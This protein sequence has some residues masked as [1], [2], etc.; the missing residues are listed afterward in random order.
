MTQFLTVDEVLDLHTDLVTRFG[1]IAG[2]RDLGLLESAL[3]QPSLALAYTQLTVFELAAIYCFGIIKNH[4]F[5]DG[6]KRTGLLAAITFLYHNGIEIE[7]SFE[8]LYKLAVGIADS[9]YQLSFI[10][11]F[12]QKAA[13][14]RP[15]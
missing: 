10:A 4:P 11:T 14:Q 13:T 7:C 3:A 9:S 8:Q 1:G 15:R 2:I 12:F 6:N 5:L